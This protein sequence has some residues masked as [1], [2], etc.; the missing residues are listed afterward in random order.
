MADA[1]S[2][3]ELDNWTVGYIFLKQAEIRFGLN[4]NFDTELWRFSN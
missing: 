4:Y 1:N 2:K 3:L